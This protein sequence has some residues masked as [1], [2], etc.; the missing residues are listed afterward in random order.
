MTQHITIFKKYIINESNRFTCELLEWYRHEHSIENAGIFVPECVINITY[1][2]YISTE[3]VYTL[4]E[5]RK[6]E[7]LS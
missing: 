1:S 3:R 6:Q 2:N 7:I 5:D 4:W